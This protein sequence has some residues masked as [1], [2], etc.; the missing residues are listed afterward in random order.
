MIDVVERCRQ[1][2]VEHPLTL[3]PAAL[4]RRVDRLDRVV[5][6]ASRSEPVRA[7]LEPCLPL[8]FQRVSDPGLLHPV[9]QHRYPQ[10][11]LLPIRFRDVDPLDRRAATAPRVGGGPP[12]MPPCPTRSTRPRRRCPRSCG[13]RW[14]RH[15]PNADQRVRPAPQHQLLQAADP[16]KVPGLRRLEDP[17]PQPPNVIL[18]RRQ[19]R[20]RPNRSSSSPVRSPHRCPT[21]PRLKRRHHV[22]PKAHLAHVSTPF[23]SAQTRY[24]ASYPTRRLEETAFASRFPAAFRPPALASWAILFPPG[25]GLP[26]GRPTGP[27]RP[28]PGRGFHV[29]HAQDPAGEGAALSRGGGVHAAGKCPPAA[30]CRFSAASPAPRYHPSTRGSS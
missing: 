20:S 3:G 24:P 10:W 8:R 18:N 1:V 15:P 22:S 25:F 30:A 28:G 14:L 26:H 17:L 23:G 2:R 13:Q 4:E 6:A 16:L 9:P 7:R 11:P 5:T 19:S 29:P 21:C 27:A 12:P